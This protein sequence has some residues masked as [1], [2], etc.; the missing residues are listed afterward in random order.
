MRV[1]RDYQ[2]AC[3]ACRAHRGQPCTG[4]QG[5]RLAGVHFQRTTALRAQAMLAYKLL[6]SPLPASS[7]ASSQNQRVS[8]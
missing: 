3:P 4:K 6:L 1:R 5:E 7:Y 8:Q 2:T